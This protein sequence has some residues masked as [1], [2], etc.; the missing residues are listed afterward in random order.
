[1][2]SFVYNIYKSI[3]KVT[4][5]GNHF[6]HRPFFD[7]NDHKFVSKA[8]NSQFISTAGESTYEF[9]KKISKLTKSNYCVSTISGTSAIQIALLASGV[10]PYDEVL[11]PALTFVGTAN[12][13]SHC[14]AI[15]HFVD[16]N[17]I[18]F[19]IDV[20]KL[21]DYLKKNFKI[22]KRTLINKNSGRKVKAIV[23][24]HVFGHACSINEINK[25]AKEFRLKVIEDAAE[26]LGSYHKSKHLGTQSLFGCLSFN[27]NKIITTGGG[28]AIITNNLNY[29]KIAKHLATTAKIPHKYKYIHDRI[30]FNYRMPSL[31][32]S[33]GIAQLLKLKKFLSAKR[34]LYSEYEKSFS[35]IDGAKIYKE[36]KNSKSNYWLQTLIL[37]D[38]Y[39]NLKEKIINLCISK[40]IFVR[41]SWTLLSKLKPY[42][43]FPKMDLSGA[44]NI[45]R[46]II[47]LPSSQSI[48][49]KK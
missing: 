4:G 48:I 40:N 6:L 21:K 10:R 47:S 33:I 27:G 43:N 12:A 8:I 46:K 36:D 3:L 23:P 11:V 7:K 39:V 32:A 31:N 17:I 35:K 44:K 18:N 22:S 37:D 19:G 30:G 34:E 28:G 42:R 49:L 41:P 14:G 45:E 1:M 15:P 24:V 38:K 5:R 20:E 2:K 25:I 9:E 26:A 13:I 16:S 29:F